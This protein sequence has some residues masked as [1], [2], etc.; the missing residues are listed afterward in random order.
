MSDFSKTFNVE[1]ALEFAKMVLIVDDKNRA[2][3][4]PPGFT[5]YS[6]NVKTF[7]DND[8]WNNAFFMM[9]NDCDDIDYFS[10]MRDEKHESKCKIP[11]LVDAIRRTKGRF[12]VSFEDFELLENEI[13]FLKIFDS[14]GFQIQIL[15]IENEMESIIARL[16][17]IDVES[18]EINES[19]CFALVALPEVL[20]YYT[21]PTTEITSTYKQSTYTLLSIQDE[22]R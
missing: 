2:I 3:N 5:E 1:K 21:N 13:D 16:M 11:C 19:F 10:S 6:E 17:R 14:Y 9:L 20:Q 7:K 22:N 12:Q 18:D 15:H 8:L 4:G